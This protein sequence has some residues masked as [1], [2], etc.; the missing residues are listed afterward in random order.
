MS[1]NMKT[2][3]AL[4]V[5]VSVAHQV[6]S[7]SLGDSMS[8]KMRQAKPAPVDCKMSAWSEW[9]PCNPCTKTTHRSRGIEAFGQ[10][11]GTVCNQALGDRKPCKT[12]AMCVKEPKEPC[13]AMEFQCDS[14]LC[15]KKRLMC[16]G[17]NDCG[18]WSDEDACEQEGRRPCGNM[19]LE[20]SEMGR[21][22]GHGVNILGS[23]PRMNPFN[24]EYFN[25]LCSRVRDTTTLAYHRL[26]WNIGVL[27]Y[28]TKVEE[29]ASKEIYEDMHSLIKEIMK[30]TTDTINVDLSFKFTPTEE[31]NTSISASVGHTQ[32]LE[33]T[34]MIKQVSELTV[35]KNKSFMRVKGSV[36]LS[37]Y[38][39]RS[40][41]LMLTETFLEDVAALPVQYEKGQY[42]RFLEDY[43]THYTTNG[44]LGGEYELVY[45][46][47]QENVRTKEITERMM[48]ECIK[49]GVKADLSFMEGQGGLEVNEKPEH[50]DKFTSSQT[51]QSEGKALIDKVMSS[52]R[53]G[54]VDAA[55]AMRTKIEKQGLLDTATYE[56]WARTIINSPVP[57]HSDPEPIYNL[58]PLKM[59]HSQ[60]RRENIRLAT[61]AYVAEYSVCKCQPCQNGGTVSQIDGKCICLC[62]PQ[63]EGLACETVRSDLLKGQPIVQEGNWGCWSAW[64]NCSG[65][66]RSR[67]RIC[68]TQGLTDATCRGETVS[69]DYC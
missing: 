18:D 46:L 24:N 49:I 63:F 9:G 52:V 19:D 57:I 56:S 30:E 58:I 35:T 15:I 25:G 50:C 29:A 4:F 40:N 47:N 5:A 59:S 39:L 10:F 6:L 12:D 31:S 38:R 21:I 14:G 44:R 7:V 65:G 33:E 3:A 45:V 13:T 66:K 22:A 43:G 32:Q 37:T 2:L 27:S 16:N 11:D 20:L 8:R 28:E 34:D 55:A 60:E 1:V 26:P 48:Q 53:G 62:K 68:N 23:G 51:E 67:N 54:T 64:S 69:T 42:F 41:S 61:E 36:Q 17:D